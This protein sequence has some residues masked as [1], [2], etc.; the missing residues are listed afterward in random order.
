MISPGDRATHWVNGREV[1]CVEV[2]ESGVSG[3]CVRYKYVLGDPPGDGHR[4]LA[5]R[6]LWMV[7]KNGSAPSGKKH[8]PGVK[9][10]QR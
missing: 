10:R 2:W 5:D 3:E 6:W 7:S 1:E 8:R 9:V 4:M